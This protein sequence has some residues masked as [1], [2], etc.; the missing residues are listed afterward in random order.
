MPNKFTKSGLALLVIFFIPTLFLVHVQFPYLRL[1]PSLLPQPANAQRNVPDL[2]KPSPL[3]VSVEDEGVQIEWRMAEMELAKANDYEFEQ[4]TWDNYSGYLIP[5]ATVLVH[6]PEERRDEEVSIEIVSIES[7]PWTKKIPLAATE[8]MLGPD[9][10]E[11]PNAQPTELKLPTEPIFVARK[12]RQR[13]QTLV[14]L[15]V[16]PLY[17]SEDGPHVVTELIALVKDVV[18]PEDASEPNRPATQPDL[19]LST[20]QAASTDEVD[21]G[22]ALDSPL[23]T[24]TTS[25]RIELV[26]QTT[27]ELDMDSPLPTTEAAAQGGT[28]T[29]KA[30]RTPT[31]T[32]RPTKTPT[33]KPTKRPT[34]TKTATTKPTAKSTTT[35]TPSATAAATAVVSPTARLQLILPL[36]TPEQETKLIIISSDAITGTKAVTDTA[37]DTETAPAAEVISPNTTPSTDLVII[38]S[39][40]QDTITD[41]ETMTDTVF[42]PVTT[43]DQTEDVQPENAQAENVQPELS[44]SIQPSTSNTTTQVVLLDDEPSPANRAREQIWTLPRYMSRTWLVLPIF[45]AFFGSVMLLLARKPE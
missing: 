11:L 37:A 33:A 8:T 10:E 44:A 36:E 34:V 21:E 18:L 1:A 6:L 27:A 32:K 3:N 41:T 19:P 30:T 7:S 25:H 16:H 2:L 24:P 38:D 31:A 13:Q 4:W 43:I 29:E 20:V 35:Q 40:I 42:L 5:S 39:T 15:S 9:G 17:E 26:L 23:A 12:G 28:V 14:V 45:L 22:S